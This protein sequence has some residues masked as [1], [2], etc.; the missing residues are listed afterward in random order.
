[1][2][3]QMNDKFIFS[4]VEYGI[5]SI[6]YPKKYFNINSL[7]LKP[8]EFHTAC[9]RG[10][11][12]TYA[13]SNGNLVLNKLYTNNGNNKYYDAPLINNKSP[14]IEIPEDLCDEYKDSWK[15]Y[16]YEDIGL[17]LNYTGSVLITKDFV[18]KRYVH[19]G[20]QSPFNYN[21]VI[22]IMFNNG[23]LVFSE[24][25]SKIAASLREEKNIELTNE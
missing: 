4:N 17:K 2:T 13:L 23:K 6:E 12:A 14:K 5:S 15:E 7:G 10:Y 19:M 3:A 24:D 9:W 18:S 16:I 8:I 21:T 22:Q 1:M 25:L 11:I 20:F